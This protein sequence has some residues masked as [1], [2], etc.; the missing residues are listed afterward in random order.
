MNQF[1]HLYQKLENSANAN[2][3]IE[4]LVDYFKNST[5]R[6][7]VW[8][9][10]LLSNNK[11]SAI[12]PK[13]KLTELIIN[14]SDVPRWL[15]EETGKHVGD[16]IET[17]SLLSPNGEQSYR[18]EQLIS[19]WDEL[20]ETADEKIITYWDGMSQ[21]DRFVFG[22]LLT[23]T[24]LISIP[25]E[26]MAR[27]IAEFSGKPLA[28]LITDWDPR[29]AKFSELSSTNVVTHEHN[30]TAVLM[31]IIKSGKSSPEYGFGV[32]SGDRLVSIAK[33]DASLE[34]D[35]ILLIDAWMKQN[36]VEQFG[37]AY[38]V[39]PELVFDLTFSEVVASKR[40]KAGLKLVH[41]K[42][43]V[44]H[45]DKKIEDIDKLELLTG[46]LS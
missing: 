9:V 28:G 7:Q 23:G 15:I 42:I 19:I 25:T 34:R 44:W 32:R 5:E 35:E 10:Y 33:V 26:I 21:A 39:K 6:D 16:M 29:I 20:K 11:L 37:M 30:V 40:H 14:K 8:A 13:A 4:A 43:V 24:K 41:P 45:K 18:L 27:A 38:M 12:I 36:T 17:L 22:R 3:R 1:S 46:L 31:S 2:D